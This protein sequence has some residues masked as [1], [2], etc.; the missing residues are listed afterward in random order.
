MIDR[1]KQNTRQNEWKKKNQDSVH[2]MLPKGMKEK[3]K[4]E[5]DAEG[6]SLTQYIIEKVSRGI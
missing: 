5:A 1:K 4:A 6:L 3:W 2:L